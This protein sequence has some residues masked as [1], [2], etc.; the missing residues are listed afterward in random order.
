MVACAEFD[1]P[2]FQAEFVALLQAV[3]RA[4]GCLPSVHFASG[5]NHYT[6]A[7]HIGTRDVRLA[8]EVLAFVRE[9]CATGEHHD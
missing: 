5:H 4:R 2:R 3:H 6:I 9:N 8:D 1:P 7:M